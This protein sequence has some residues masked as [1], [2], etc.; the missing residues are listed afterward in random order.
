MAAR[1]KLSIIM[2]LGFCAMCNVTEKSWHESR[3]VEFLH[4]GETVTYTLG[5]VYHGGSVGFL[6]F[7]KDQDVSYR[8]KESSEE[9]R[10]GLM[11][12]VPTHTVVDSDGKSYVRDSSNCFF[13]ISDASGWVAINDGDIGRLREYIHEGGHK[14]ATRT[15]DALGLS[16]L[17]SVEDAIIKKW[18][19]A[20]Q[21]E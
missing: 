1:R 2:M 16:G 11:V 17:M 5:C 19:K 20:I 13:Y 7:S 10:G 12:M 18:K 6:V 4:D 21:E 9:K 3:T 14:T 8:Y 15:S